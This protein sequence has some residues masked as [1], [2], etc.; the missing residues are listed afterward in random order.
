MRVD[1]LAWLA[2]AARSRRRRRARLLGGPVRPPGPGRGG[3]GVPA[4]RRRSAAA[5]C[6]AWRSPPWPPNEGSPCTRTSGGPRSSASPPTCT[7]RWRPTSPGWSTTS[8]PTSRSCR[9][10]AVRRSASPTSR[11]AHLRGP[12]GTGPG[13]RAARR[14]R[15][16]LPVRRRR[17]LRRGLPRAREGSLR[18]VTGPAA[19]DRPGIE[20]EDSARSSTSAARR[21]SPSTAS[22]TWRR[23]AA[24]PRSSG[25]RAV[26]SRRPAHHRR[27]RRP[28]RGTVRVHGEAAVRRPPGPPPRHRLPGPRP[29]ALADGHATT[30]ASPCRPP[31]SRAGGRPSTTSLE[32]GRAQRVREGPAPP[33]VGRHAPARGHRPGAG[34]RPAGA[35]ARRAVRRARRDD[36]AADEHRAAADLDGARRPP[37]CS[38]PTRSTRPC[39]SPTRSS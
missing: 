36:A 30:S 33:A 18:P 19:T 3:P 29:A 10:S 26:A 31:G 21:S 34:H 24:S 28:H 2:P 23:P 39:S 9:R 25:R 14:R 13:R 16:A 32:A 4:R 20:L 22:T 17:H 37:R 5:S 38:S 6:R 11:A 12:G 1:D 7:G 15:R 27:P 35:A 8:T